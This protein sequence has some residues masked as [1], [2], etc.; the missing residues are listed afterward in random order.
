MYYFSHI[1]LFFMFYSVI[2]WCTEV[3]YK[4][5][6]T[7]KFVNRGFLNGPLCPIYGVGATIVILLLTPLQDNLLL[8]YIGSVILT[9]VL[10]FLTG[11]VLEVIFHQKWWDY[12]NEHF[13]IKGYVCLKFSLLWGIGCVL[14]MKVVQPIVMLAYDKTPNTLKNIS[15]IIFYS[16]MLADLIITVAALAKVGL[17]LKLA[18]D[19][20]NFLNKVAEALGSRISATTLKSMEE[21][22]EQKEKLSDITDEA[23]EHTDQVK[24][25]MKATA[26]KLMKRYDSYVAFSSKKYGEEF[27]GR[28]KFSFVH[29]RLEKAYP[30]L[31]F[32]RIESI[33]MRERIETLNKKFEDFTENIGNVRL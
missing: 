4:T 23:K 32:K 19:L 30:S 14:I 22:G 2:G 5:T 31:N 20:D 17:Q 9:S 15:F 27:T 24:D 21:I 10:E 12:T 16:F 7:G 29:K 25:N 8:L 18:N 3:I 33:S 6:C 26:S 28:E 11:F 13:N 1:L